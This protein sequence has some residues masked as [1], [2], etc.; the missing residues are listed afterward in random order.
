[1]WDDDSNIFSPR[2][3]VAYASNT[4]R[5]KR[6]NRRIFKMVVD[7]LRFTGNVQSQWLL[8][9]IG[10]NNMVHPPQTKRT[11]SN[12]EKTD[13]SWRSNEGSKICAFSLFRIWGKVLLPLRHVLSQLIS[14]LV[15]WSHFSASLRYWPA[16]ALNQLSWYRLRGCYT[17]EREK[18]LPKFPTCVT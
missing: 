9:G 3:R 10:K 17:E 2:E 1:M 4:S 12:T 7:L 6:I 5:R 18:V 15:R 8:M 13:K 14:F 16:R 11:V